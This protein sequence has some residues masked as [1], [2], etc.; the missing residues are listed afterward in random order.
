MIEQIV[1]ALP[2]ETPALAPPVQPFEQYPC[3]LP[4]ELV[5]PVRVVHHSVVVVIPTKLQLQLR[6]EQSKANVAILLAPLGEVGQRVSEF[7]S[8]SP[9]VQM[10]P[11][12][13]I[14]PPEELEAEEVKPRRSRLLLP[15]EANHPSL[16]S[17]QLQTVLLEPKL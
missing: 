9:A 7:L 13:A 12:L 6:E 14:P 3:R 15:A 5:Q 16:V 17:R 2:V 10:R 4:V 11:A 1:E 8:R